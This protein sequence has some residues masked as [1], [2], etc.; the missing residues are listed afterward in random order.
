MTPE[1]ALITGVLTLSA[2]VGVAATVELATQTI[3]TGLH[4]VDTSEHAADA[5]RNDLPGAGA[6]A[7]GVSITVALGRRRTR[8][9]GAK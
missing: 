5:I 4:A 6:G 8:K 9:G 3:D 2:V 7:G 1:G